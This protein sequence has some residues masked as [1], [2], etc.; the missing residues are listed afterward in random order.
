MDIATR[1]TEMIKQRD[2][3]ELKLQENY[4]AFRAIQ[5][6]MKH[7]TELR[8]ECIIKLEMLDE[9]LEGEEDG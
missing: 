7:D 8:D 4:Q 3:L 2:A 1:K 6:E 9:I 5:E